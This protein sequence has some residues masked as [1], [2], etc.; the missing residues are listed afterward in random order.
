MVCLKLDTDAEQFV[1]VSVWEW[2]SVVGLF[3]APAAE[4]DAHSL[5]NVKLL[6]LVHGDIWGHEHIT[7]YTLIELH[8]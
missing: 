3:W 7:L 5:P 2:V 8:R 1:S 4:A 6:P